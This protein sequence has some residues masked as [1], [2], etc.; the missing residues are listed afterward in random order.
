MS[1]FEEHEVTYGDD[2]KIFYLAAGPSAGPLIIFMHGWP[3]IGKT[4]HDQ[5]IP[6]ASLGFRVVAPD[7]PGYGQSTARKVSS[8]Y[9][10]E[11]IVQGMLAVLA[12]TK[13]EEAIWV[14]HDWG[15][16]TLWTL[17]N[18]HP[19]VCRAVAGLCVPS[20]SLEF[21]LE[22]LL[23]TVSRDVYPKAEYPYGQWSYQA[24]YEQDLEKVTNWMDSDAHGFLKA[25][26]QNRDPAAWGKPAFSSNVVKDNG[27]FEGIPQPPSVSDTPDGTNCID[28]E[29]FKELIA[30]MKKNGFFSAN[31]WYLNHK[32]NREYNLKHTKNN[33]R[34]EMPVLFIHGK[35]DVVCDTSVGLADQMRKNCTN[36]TETTI[37]S[38]HWVLSEK[39][40]ETNAAL[41]R[42]IVEEVADWWPGYWKNGFVK[43]RA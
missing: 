31:S 18:T 39:P 10:Q 23:K 8:D 32:A 12:D 37:D 28:E 34:L 40:A 17:A 41:A 43:R 15:C 6:F 5:L 33:G 16:G 9:A 13:R 26:M 21:G 42:W 1:V 22:E 19:H 14:G 29:T 30:A 24:F 20:H 4:W 2:K 38:G 35:F 7:M 25:V 36:L 3:G 11:N 27:W